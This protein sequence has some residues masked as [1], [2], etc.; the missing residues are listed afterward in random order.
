M[1]KQGITLPPPGEYGV[2]MVFLPQRARP[3]GAPAKQEIERA[4]RDEGPD[5]ARLARCAARQQR[6]GPG[7]QGHRAGDAPGVHRRAAGHQRTP[8]PWSAS[9]TSSARPSGHHHPGAEAAGRQDVLRAVDVGAHHRLQGHAA[10]RP[11]RRVL[12]RPAGSAHGVGAGPGAPALLH[13]HLPDLGSGASVPH[14]R[15]QRRDQHAARQRQL[16]AR[17]PERRSPRQCSATISTR[18]GR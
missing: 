3:A 15:P 1:A 4:I 16:D 17:A 6:A 2:G 11:G 14:D 7:R 12:P 8:T 10:G 5:A 9:S 13:Q 18:S